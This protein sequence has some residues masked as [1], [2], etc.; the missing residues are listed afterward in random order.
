MQCPIKRVELPV[1]NSCKMLRYLQVWSKNL[2]KGVKV[3]KELTIKNLES[4]F[5]L[6]IKV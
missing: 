1:S 6:F 5:N 2:K 3:L 4:V